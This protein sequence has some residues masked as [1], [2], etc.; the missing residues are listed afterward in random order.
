MEYLS[1]FNTKRVHL[2]ANLLGDWINLKEIDY[3]N[4]DTSE[5][6]EMGFMFFACSSLTSLDISYFTLKK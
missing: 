4:F 2:M 6:K 5:V 1:K 3:S